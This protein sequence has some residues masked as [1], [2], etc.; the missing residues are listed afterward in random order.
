MTTGRNWY[1]LMLMVL[2]IFWVVTAWVSNNAGQAI[3][4]SFPVWSQTLWY[5]GLVVGALV[6]TIG[7]VL[8]N[9]I[10][11]LVEKSGLLALVGICAGYSVAFLSFAGRAGI[12][13]VILIVALIALYAGINW[14]RVWQINKEIH[15]LKLGLRKLATPETM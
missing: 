7:I 2:T 12:V 4:A 10:G 14:A 13:H 9:F 8:H 6:T 5:G 11:L 3:T 15:T 1:Q